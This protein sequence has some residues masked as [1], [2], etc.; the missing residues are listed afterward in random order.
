MEEVNKQNNIN[1]N[2]NTSYNFLLLS[3]YHYLKKNNFTETSEKLFQE[4]KL[5]SIFKFPDNLP[6][7]QNEKEKIT[8]DFIRFFYNNSFNNDSNFDLLSD[9][10]N[11]FWGIF[12]NK[13]CMGNNINIK[14]LYENEEKNIS[15]CSYSQKNFIKKEKND[16]IKE[17]FNSIHTHLSQKTKNGVNTHDID[18]IENSSQVKKNKENKSD[19]EEEE[20]EEMDDIEQEMDE[21]NGIS[22][23]N[24]NS[25]NIIKRTTGDH[26]PVSIFEHNNSC[27]KIDY[28]YKPNDIPSNCKINFMNRNQ[29]D[30]SGM[31]E[32]HMGNNAFEGNNQGF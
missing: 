28:S 18:N 32:M 23:N 2:N 17:N 14:T 9:F 31:S 15:K 10:W 1:N 26:I 29:N 20:E 21:E 6:E 5:D 22:F 8:N 16:F 4:C 30:V 27:N 12:T 13:M 19:D 11:Q 25:E 7:P 24:K 3:L